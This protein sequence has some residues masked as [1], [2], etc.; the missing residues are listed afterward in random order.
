MLISCPYC[1]ET[2]ARKKLK[3]PMHWSF[4]LILLGFL[5]GMIGGLF[6]GLG[7]ESK[8][9]CEKCGGSFLSH[10]KV[11]RVFFVLCVITYSIVAAAI[12]YG[13]WLAFTSRH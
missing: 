2:E 4:G 7:Q 8:F 11:S 12:A 6:Y 3:R 9:R 1:G 5:G 13:C 10:T